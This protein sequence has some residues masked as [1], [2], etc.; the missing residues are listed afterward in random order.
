MSLTLF[1]LEQLDS[2]IH[3]SVL[4]FADDLRPVGTCELLLPP[5]RLVGSLADDLLLLVGATLCIL[6]RCAA[7]FLDV[8][9]PALSLAWELVAH[10]LTDRVPT[11]SAKTPVHVVPLRSQIL[12]HRHVVRHLL[13]IAAHLCWAASVSSEIVET[14]LDGVELR[15]IRAFTRVREHDHSKRIMSMSASTPSRVFWSSTACCCT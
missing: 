8:L 15:L 10:A 1:P 2:L 9:M 7:L 6:H 12:Q 13:C 5:P 3:V 14:V 11:S 4:I